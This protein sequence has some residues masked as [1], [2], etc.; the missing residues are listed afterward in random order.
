MVR[1]KCGEPGTVFSLQVE[2][3]PAPEDFQVKFFEHNQYKGSSLI[4][5]LSKGSNY[6]WKGRGA[7][8][9][10]GHDYEGFLA[11]LNS[12]S[13]VKVGSRFMPLS[14]VLFIAIQIGN[15]MVLSEQI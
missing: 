10:E 11:Y 8:V 12:L 7:I 13:S 2:W 4:F 5:D 9:H 14:Q 15:R 6:W 1:C 3:N